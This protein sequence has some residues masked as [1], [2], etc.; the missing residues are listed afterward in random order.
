MVDNKVDGRADCVSC[1]VVGYKQPGGFQ[2]VSDAA[3]LGNVQC[4]S[5]H[6]M[7]TKHESYPAQAQQITEAT[8][9]QCHNSTTS[10]TFSFAI[11]Q[12]HVL[13]HPPANMPPLP[14]NPNK[15]GM[16]SGH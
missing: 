15:K 7:G 3:K 10:P 13:H 6:G 12:P 5:C 2:S 8:C 9:T 14:E 16:T 11:Y 1:H 4:E